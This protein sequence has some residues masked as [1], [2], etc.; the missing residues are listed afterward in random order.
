MIRDFL[1][2]YALAIADG[3][4]VKLNDTTLKAVVDNLERDEEL[5]EFIDSKVMEHVTEQKTNELEKLI[6]YEKEKQK[7]C[8]TSKQDLM[9]L[10][11][12]EEELERLS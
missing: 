7:V 4:E 6:K 11:E 1:K 3:M 8:A 2:E 5:F 9:Y 12:L 10:E